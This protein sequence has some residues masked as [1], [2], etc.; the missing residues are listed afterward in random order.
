MPITEYPNQ[1]EF[2][3]PRETTIRMSKISAS[4]GTKGLLKSIST[5]AIDNFP[6]HLEFMMYG[7]RRSSGE[8]S[9]AYLFLPDGMATP[10]SIA[11]PSTVLL[12][13][14][15]LESSCATAFPHIQHKTILRDGEHAL[16]IRNLVDIRETANREFV[17]RVSSS[18]NSKETFFTDL[19]GFQYMKRVRF[20]KIPLQ[21]NYYPIPSGIYIEDDRVRMTLLTSQPLGGSSLASGQIEIMQDRHLEQDDNRGLGQG[22]QDNVPTLN[23]FKLGLEHIESCAKRPQNYAGGFL[24]ETMH[25]EMNLIMYPMEKLVWHEND[26]W[27]GVLPHFGRDHKSLEIGTEIAVLRNLKYV[28][29]GRKDRKTTIG[30]VINRYHLEQC[31]GNKGK[32]VKVN[33]LHALGIT[34]HVDVFNTTLTMLDKQQKL[35]TP[36]VDICPMDIKAFIVNRSGH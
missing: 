7:V 12:T 13:V 25:T 17:M 8:R 34:Q 36:A 22:V 3:E 26:A 11:A 29:N 10:I 31:D 24:T 15:I 28:R 32:S 2:N 4:F 21:A 20:D 33:L 27:K 23:I 14:G 6:I 9:G 19:N 16:E 1:V 18:I 5:D 30:M 35:T